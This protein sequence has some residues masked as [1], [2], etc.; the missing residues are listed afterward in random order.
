MASWEDEPSGG[1]RE[2]SEPSGCTDLI[3]PPLR[4][5]SPPELLDRLLLHDEEEEET[6]SYV[7]SAHPAP[8]E[9]GSDD[10]AG[11]TR[12]VDDMYSCVELD[13][14]VDKE[15]VCPAVL[16][17]F[18]V[19]PFQTFLFNVGLESIKKINNHIHFLH[20][21]QRVE[22]GPAD[23][24]QGFLKFTPKEISRKWLA[25]YIRRNAEH[26]EAYKEF[27]A[28]GYDYAQ[29]LRY[30]LRLFPKTSYHCIKKSIY[31]DHHEYL[32]F[33]TSETAST[34]GMNEPNDTLQIFSLKLSSNESY[35]ISVYGIFAVRDE[36]DRLRN[37]VFNR[38]RDNPVLI[39]QAESEGGGSDDKQ[40]LS[41]Y[42][43]IENRG[44]KDPMIYGRIPSDRCLLDVDCMFLLN[45]VE[46][47]I[48]VF[49]KDDSDNPHRVRFTAFSSG[50]DHEIVLYDDRLCKK[51]KLF[52]NVVAVKSKEKL[53][54]RLEFEGSTF[55]W[56][57][58]DGAVAAVSSPDDSV[59]KLFDVVVQIIQQETKDK[60][61]WKFT[62]N[63]ICSTKSAYKEVYKREISN[64]HQLWKAR[65]DLKFQGKIKEP[66]QVCMEAKAMIKTY[67]NFLS[68]DLMQEDLD[69]EDT[70]RRMGGAASISTGNGDCQILEVHFLTDSAII[71][72]TLAREETFK[73]NQGIGA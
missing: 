2:P 57:F 23:V 15:T 68:N 53:V 14:V 1:S 41:E 72:R 5:K 20:C 49:T 36:L 28:S 35:P 18:P 16:F 31:C 71:A 26:T 27:V 51:G 65:N 63:G 54:I 56:T 8:I 10:D 11:L 43:E 47:V 12:F 64:A 33:T 55:R 19:D 39:E 4:P 61:C 70:N 21:M 13:D 60:L 73:K 7:A 32:T 52:Q 6:T 34:I 3:M 59:S 66:T 30:P 25:T 50:F 67:T 22:V 69:E 24:E 17:V 29:L 44:L 42:A 40:L 62:N 46:A 58:Q 45:S 9:Y 38:T 37:Y 48:Q